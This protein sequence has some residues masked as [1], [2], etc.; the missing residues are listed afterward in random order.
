MPVPG[1]DD[2]AVSAFV[3]QRHEA[4]ARLARVLEELVVLTWPPEEANVRTL[5]PAGAEALRDEIASL[6]S[7]I[8]LMDVERLALPLL[9]RARHLQGL[10]RAALDAQAPAP[11]PRDLDP[12]RVVT[13]H[14]ECTDP[15]AAAG[16][17]RPTAVVLRDSAT[18]KLVQI[19]DEDER[20]L[21]VRLRDEMERRPWKPVLTWNMADAGWYGWPALSRRAAALGIVLAQPRPHLDLARWLWQRHGNDYIPHGQHGRFYELATR[22]NLPTRGWH[23]GCESGKAGGTA[24]ERLRRAAVKAEAIEGVLRLAVA[25]TLRV[26]TA[27]PADANGYMSPAAIADRYDVKLEALKKR[28]ERWRE[29]HVMADGWIENADRRPNEARYLY[30]AAKVES[31]IRATK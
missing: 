7:G 14:Y 1:L 19:A 21:L 30:N 5:W 26:E 16:D 17:P 20:L 15:N 29:K 25:G 11:E 9:A 3:E 31:V 18:G 10:L 12:E 28:L 4:G 27:R 2:A 6:S 24:A 13:V 8:T 22:N 23:D